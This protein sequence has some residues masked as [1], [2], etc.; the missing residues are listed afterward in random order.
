MKTKSLLILSASIAIA[1]AVISTSQSYRRWK[2]QQ[3]KRLQAESHLFE[4]ARGPVEY[5]MEGDGPAVMVI[6]GS[7]GGYDQGM[8]LARFL[9]M[10][11]F[12]AIALSR[13]GY[14]R[15]PLTSGKTPEAQ[16]DLFAAILDMLNVPRVVIIASSGG[17]PSALQFALRHPNRCQRLVLLSALAQDYT[18]EGVYRSLPS[19]ERLFKKFFERLITFDPFLYLLFKLISFLPETT[20]LS[21]FIPSLVMNNRRTA[22]YRNDMQQFAELPAYPV[23]EIAIPTLII[24]G[25]ADVDIPFLQAEWLAKK[26]PHAQLVAIEGADHFSPLADEKG[27]AALRTFLQMVLST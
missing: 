10:S 11:A 8:A 2:W 21:A 1:T 23:Q 3:V 4:T 14:R 6:H 17:G 13:P 12:T 25:T 15:T 19:G 16:A 9:D 27:I 20:Q 18:E 22:G 5:Q 7:P 26:L 24:H